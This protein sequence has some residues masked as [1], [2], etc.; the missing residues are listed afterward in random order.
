MLGFLRVS[1]STLD[2]ARSKM[3]QIWTWLP[4]ATV[5][6]GWTN[7]ARG[8]AAAGLE[9]IDAAFGGPDARSVSYNRTLVAAVRAEALMASGRLDDAIDV[10]VEAQ[11]LIGETEE[12]WLES[13]LHRLQ[14]CTLRKCGD[15]A[16][17]EES[18]QSAIDIARDQAARIFEL[19]ATTSLAELWRSPWARCSL[20]NP[21]SAARGTPRRWRWCGWW[22]SCRT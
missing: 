2:T 16:R 17:A 10:L 22:K 11:G 8:D 6:R 3:R 9:R 19:R 12:H 1:S 20:A 15:D 14:D 5:L 13:E 21:C 7:I 18:F 4:L